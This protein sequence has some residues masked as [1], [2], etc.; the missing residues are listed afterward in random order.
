VSEETVS[1]LSTG[2]YEELKGEEFSN[3]PNNKEKLFLSK[4]F[5]KT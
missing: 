5:I 4:E 3:V 2:E 1:N